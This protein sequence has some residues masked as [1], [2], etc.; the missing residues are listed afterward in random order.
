M[1]LAANEVA[2]ESFLL[3]RIGFLQ[4]SGIIEQSFSGQE[5]FS[6]LGIPFAEP[7]T[8]KLRFKVSQKKSLDF[9]YSHI[10]PTLLGHL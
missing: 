6:Y 3:N 4:I 10:Y 5:Y 2:V 7:P 1:V 8:G 9:Y